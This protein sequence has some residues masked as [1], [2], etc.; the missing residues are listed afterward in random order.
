MLPLVMNKFENVY[1][2]LTVFIALISIEKKTTMNSS[3]IS[4]LSQIDAYFLQS[5]NEMEVQWLYLN[6]KLLWR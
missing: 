3:E 1:I 6:L 2:S 5:F 4:I